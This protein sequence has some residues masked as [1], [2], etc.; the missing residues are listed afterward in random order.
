ML[1]DLSS[2]RK[3]RKISG[4]S[5][6]KIHTASISIFLKKKVTNESHGYRV[7][8]EIQ[9]IVASKKMANKLT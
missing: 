2:S 5:E 8:K 1:S 9:I 6:M 7:I 4:S 3:Y